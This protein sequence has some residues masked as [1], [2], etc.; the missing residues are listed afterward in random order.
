MFPTDW[1]FGIVYGLFEYCGKSRRRKTIIHVLSG[2]FFQ[3]FFRIFPRD[4]PAMGHMIMNF[5]ANLLDLDNAATPFGLKAMESLQELNPN[6]DVASNS[7]IMFLC[8]ACIRIK[9]IPV[10][11]IAV[12]GCSKCI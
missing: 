5:S 3:D 1:Y 8:F 11:I 4:H 9:L 2:L 7:Q 12:S 10:T 6:K